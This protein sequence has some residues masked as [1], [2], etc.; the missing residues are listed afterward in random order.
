MY[1]FYRP[2]IASRY[3]HLFGPLNKHVSGKRFT[4]DVGV[5]EEAIAG[6][7]WNLR[8]ISS[9]PVSMIWCIVGISV[10]TWTSMVI[11]L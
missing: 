4:T 5:L 6:L 7:N 1:P 3:F 11:A 2:D 10:W 9:T 8:Q